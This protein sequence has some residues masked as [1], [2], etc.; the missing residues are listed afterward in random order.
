MLHEEVSKYRRLTGDNVSDQIP[1]LR[2]GGFLDG[3]DKGIEMGIKA[4]Q[5]VWQ[6]VWNVDIP[7]PTVPE[8]V[9]HHQQ[10]Q[11][12]LALIDKRIKEMKDEA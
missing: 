1:I 12:I 7:S 3:F 10:M 6:A 4:L 8:Y 11:E 2:L 9:E 5:E